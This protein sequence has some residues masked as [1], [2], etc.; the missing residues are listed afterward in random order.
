MKL[1]NG[2]KPEPRLD[3]LSTRKYKTETNSDC[4]LAAPF[5]TVL[6]FVTFSL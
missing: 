3:L 5:P 6:P 4:A 1:K 2:S